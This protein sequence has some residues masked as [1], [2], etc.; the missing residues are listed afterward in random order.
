LRSTGS[1]YFHCDPH[2]SHYVKVELDRVFGF[3]NFRN[4]IVW[5]RTNVHSDSKRWSDVGD[6]LLYYVKDA[7][8]GFVWNPLWMR[9][10]AEYLASKYRHVDSDGRRY[11]PDNMTASSR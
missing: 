6:R 5:K 10:S 9:H 4:E 1:F 7:R 3:G 8:A 2:A 11:E